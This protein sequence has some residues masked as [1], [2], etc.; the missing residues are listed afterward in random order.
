MS[1]TR[2]LFPLIFT[3]SLTLMAWV[4]IETFS[5]FYIIYR[6]EGWQTPKSLYSKGKLKVIRSLKPGCTWEDQ[7]LPHPHLNF[8]RNSKGKCLTRHQPVNSGYFNLN[9]FTGKNDP[10]TFD[11]LVLGGSVA[12]IMSVWR[13][14]INVMQSFFEEEMNRRFTGPRGEKIKIF[15]AAIGAGSW[16]S[17]LIATSIF[18]RQVDGILLLD[19]SNEASATWRGTTMGTPNLQLFNSF[20]H[21]YDMK[22]DL[23]NWQ[24]IAYKMRTILENSWLGHSPTLFGLYKI[25]Y[26]QAYEMQKGKHISYSSYEAQYFFPPKTTQQTQFELNA[27]YYGDT[28]RQLHGLANSLGVPS[29]HFLQPIALYRK[30]LTTEEQAVVEPFFPVPYYAKMREEFVRVLKNGVPGA[31]LTGVFEDV[32]T[33]IYEDHVHFKMNQYYRIPGYEILIEAM[34]KELRKN[35]KLKVK[36]P[37]AQ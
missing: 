35:Y 14:D 28:A 6:H 2:F 31:D 23:L 16:P 13:R 7:M 18:Y 27:R 22:G 4:G 30:E 36:A 19:G 1:K 37:P 33:T 5:Y 12:E 3:I 20:S 11:I 24:R 25:A 15:N 10:G 8:V 29:V 26:D 32:K 9:K 34:S 21:A 17:P